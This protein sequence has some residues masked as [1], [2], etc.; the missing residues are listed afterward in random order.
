MN[1]LTDS[2]VVDVL[3]GRMAAIRD[4]DPKETTQLSEELIRLVHQISIKHQYD[5]DIGS[6][7]K[8]LGNKIDDLVSEDDKS[9]GESE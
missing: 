8:E 4:E 3:L 5:D 7:I 9:N 6:L 1:K 2:R